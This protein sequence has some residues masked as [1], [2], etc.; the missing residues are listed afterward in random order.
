M[1]YKVDHQIT[2]TE[3]RKNGYYPILRQ[4]T[5][6]CQQHKVFAINHQRSI[7]EMYWKHTTNHRVVKPGKRTMGGA[8]PGIRRT[9]GVQKC[10]KPIN[11]FVQRNRQK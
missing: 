2:A 11:R 3:S 4:K 10:S 8:D 7:K 5:Y 1:R 6:R 9:L